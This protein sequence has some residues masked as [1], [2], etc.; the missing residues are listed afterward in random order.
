MWLWSGADVSGVFLAFPSHPV[1]AWMDSFLWPAHSI[2]SRNVFL[3]HMTM[4]IWLFW[5]H[6]CWERENGVSCIRSSFHSSNRPL[7]S[8]CDVSS[9]FKEHKILLMAWTSLEATAL[10]SQWKP[11]TAP[12]PLEEMPRDELDDHWYIVKNLLKMLNLL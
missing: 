6:D 3:W 11:G 5:V 4:S 2:I 7:P 10:R 8:F 9:I 12:K 1:V